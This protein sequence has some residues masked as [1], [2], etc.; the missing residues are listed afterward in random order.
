M[1]D[2]FGGQDRI[3]AGLP[4]FSIVI[5]VFNRADRIGRTID[6]CIAQR[7]ADF[8]I[9]VVDD[10]STDGTSDLVEAMQD[11]RIRCIRQANAGASAARNKGAQ[12]AGGSFL[13]FLDSDDEFLSE[14]LASIHD[15]IHADGDADGT[16]WYSPL[17]FDRGEGNRMVKPPRPI[18]DDEPVGD[19]L[20]AD[21]GLMQTS[22]LV[23]PRALF[24]QVQFDPTLRCLEDLDLCLRLEEAGARFRMVP[25]PLVTWH[26]DTPVG[27]LSYTTSTAE[28]REWADMQSDRLT[29][30][31][32]RGYLARF[33]APQI[34]RSRPLQG[35]SM[36][37]AAVRHGSLTPKRAAMLLARG[38]APGL[39]GRLRDRL[40]RARNA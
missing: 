32:R 38:G 29:P 31:A 22:T 24:L 39:Y 23:V 11:I 20:F 10:G 28:L 15:A 9:I 13:A 16:V 19:Y 17:F 8:E 12:E 36:L 21:D 26:D 6:S 25:E 4:Y 18:G 35:A 33:L 5:P 40:T 2:D 7:F 27:R 30:R 37:A 3:D 1:P 14:K 34:L